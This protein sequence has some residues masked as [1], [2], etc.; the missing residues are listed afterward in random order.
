MVLR[1]V[2]PIPLLAHAGA[3]AEDVR[4][5]VVVVDRCAPER[6]DPGPRL[7]DGAA[8]L[9]GNEDAPHREVAPWVDAFLAGG[10]AQV[11]GVGR[12]GPHRRRL[13]LLKDQQQAFGWQG[14]GV[15]AQCTELLRAEHAGTADE[16]GEVQG[17]TVAVFRP[18]AR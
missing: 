4:Q 12:R 17:V 14:A 11:P 3:R 18:Q 16:Q 13:E 7:G 8:R 15:D 9:A 1:P 2:E 6:L 10:L 5:P